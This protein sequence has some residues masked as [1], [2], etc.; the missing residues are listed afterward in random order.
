MI[1]I[2]LFII[3]LIS[4]IYY[5]KSNHSIA[6]G[7]I[8]FIMEGFTVFFI[9]I[10]VYLIVFAGTA[11]QE[12]NTIEKPI[13]SFIDSKDSPIYVKYSFK[14]DGGSAYKYV[15]QNGKYPEYNEISVKSDVNVVEGNYDPVLIVHSYV[16]TKK[17][18]FLLGSI[19]ALFTHESWY[20]FYIP[21][22]T[23]ITY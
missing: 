7:I 11:N 22:G 6:Y 10:F 19:S 21:E 4:S 2:I 14:W 5:G 16:P 18:K 8:V 1:P 9:F 20:E 13:T 15:E 3:I 23:F 17:A 12:M